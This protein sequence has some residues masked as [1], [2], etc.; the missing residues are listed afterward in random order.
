ML[1]KLTFAPPYPLILLTGE[2]TKTFRVTRGERYQVGDELSM[3]FLDGKEFAQATVSDNYQRQF[4]T[5]T[6]EDWQGHERFSSDKEMYDIYSNWE[7]FRVGPETNLRVICWKDFMLTGNLLAV[8]FKAAREVQEQE[9]RLE[10]YDRISHMA[11][12]LVP[13]TKYL[14][15][16]VPGAGNLEFS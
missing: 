10:V 7:G 11:D 16:P 2:K 4:K 14:P 9:K 12:H 8:D 6:P 15:G 3:V 5:L 1:K 13:E